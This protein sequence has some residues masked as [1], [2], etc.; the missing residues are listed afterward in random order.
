[1]EMERSGL[2]ES[3]SHDPLAVSIHG[4]PAFSGLMCLPPPPAHTPAGPTPNRHVS[5]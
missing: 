5:T 3:R 2:A 1:M 4:M